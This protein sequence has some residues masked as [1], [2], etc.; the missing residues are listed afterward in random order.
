MSPPRTSTSLY[1]ES[2]IER[3]HPLTTSDQHLDLIFTLPVLMDRFP[4]LPHGDHIRLVLLSIQSR[5]VMMSMLEVSV[6]LVTCLDLLL[7]TTKLLFIACLEVCVKSI[8]GF[9]LEIAVEGG[10]L[11]LEL[12]WLERLDLLISHMQRLRRG[13]E[14]VVLGKYLIPLLDPLP[15][16]GTPSGSLSHTRE[17]VTLGVFRVGE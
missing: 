13:G 16:C 10:E 8:K 6:L 12:G 5:A 4:V 2:T 7:Q 14:E 9:L 17:H 11:R 3:R 1:Q 15:V